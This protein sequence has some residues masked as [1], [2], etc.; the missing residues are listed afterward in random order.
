MP[1]TQTVEIPADR[2]LTIDVPSE[3]PTGSVILTFTP[4][5]KAPKMSAAQEIEIIN[6][7]AD[8]LNSEAID[9]LLYQ[10]IDL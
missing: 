8:R 4:A 10:D 6:R 1:I 2:R 9:V 7:N 3:V 5:S